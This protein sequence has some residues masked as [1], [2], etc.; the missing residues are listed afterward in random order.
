MSLKNSS[1]AKRG[2]TKNNLGWYKRLKIA[3]SST[4]KTLDDH[5]DQRF[6]RCKYFLIIE[7]DTMNFEAILNQGASAMG[8][9]GIKAAQ[10]LSEIGVKA[11]ISGNIGPN[12][13]NTLSAANIVI[14]VGVSGKIKNAVDK[15]NRG[16]LEK[17]ESSNVSGHFGTR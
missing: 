11:A 14:Y 5:V 12:A 4:G 8:G 15:F 3:V 7:S 6:G 10:S 17:T 9:A 2:Q 13:F 1:L 16:E